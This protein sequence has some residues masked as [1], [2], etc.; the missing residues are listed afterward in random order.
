MARIADRLSPEVIVRTSDQKYAKITLGNVKCGVFPSSKQ[1]HVAEVFMSGLLKRLSLEETEAEYI[2]YEFYDGVR[3]L[4]L[5]SVPKSQTLLVKER[6]SEF[7]VQR[8]G[9]SVRE[10]EARLLASSSDSELRPFARLNAQ[11][12]R[13]LGG[14]Y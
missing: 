7:V 6:V 9:L 12:L 4:L 11:V 2:Q 8:L 1:V 10:F 14:E 3:E 13:Q 5:Q